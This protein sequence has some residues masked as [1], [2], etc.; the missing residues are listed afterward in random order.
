MNNSMKWLTVI[1]FTGLFLFGILLANV[2]L[3]RYVM[4]SGA[5]FTI[6]L[7]GLLTS[8]TLIKSLICIELLFNSAG[9]NFIAFGYFTDLSM[10][11]GQ[12]M[13]LFTMA[14]AAAEIALGLAIAILMYHH[15][16]TVRLDVVTDISE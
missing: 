4:I 11:R 2:T 1:V 9:I 6:G 5:L 8:R 13:V 10:L 7:F 12:M 15:H 3:S 14:V 16:R